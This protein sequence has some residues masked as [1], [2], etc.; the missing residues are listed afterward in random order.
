MK[1]RVRLMVM[2]LLPMLGMGVL[3]FLGAS[4]QLKQAIEEQ[5]YSGL[6]ATALAVREIFDASGQG[7]YRLDG[8]G[9]MW[10]G[11]E[12]NISD[13]TG[14]IDA[15]KEKI[16]YDITVFYGDTRIIT[17]IVDENGSRQ[18]GTKALDEVSAQVLGKGQDYR[19]GD[20]EILGN[21][22]LCY[23]IPIY[24]EGTKNPVGMVFLGERYDR[25]LEVIQESQA[26]VLLL[27][28]LVLMLVVVTSLISANRIAK[29]I[30]G[31]I[32]SLKELGKGKLGSKVSQKLLARKDEIGDMGREVQQLDDNLTAIISEIQLQAHTLEETSS[33]CNSN[34]QKALDSAEQVDAA[35][36]EVAASTTTQAQE[37]QEA[38]RSVNA[39]GVTI[40]KTNARMKE[41][42][43]TSEKMS[44]AAGSTRDTLK[45][46]NNSMYQVKDAV[47]NIQRQTNETHISVEKISE[48]TQVIT[49]IASQTNMLSLNASIEAAR[50]GEMG[51]GFA[52]VAEEIRKL[53][54]QC[55]TSV[56]EIQ[57]AL[58]QLK[59]NSD[60]SVSIM[61]DVQKNIQQQA[62]KLIAT[63]QV[64][65]TVENGIE[66]SMQGIGTIMDE[67]G[68]LNNE[69]NT[70]VEE[71]QSV[72]VLA[73]QNA[74]SIEETTA[75]ISEVAE[76]L[77]EMSAKMQDLQSVA[78]KL[79]EKSSTF[80]LAQAQ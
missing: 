13:A 50:A 15:I 41:I 49:S 2:V 17:T 51:K 40:D 76:I 21:R 3:S 36:E 67:I 58:V 19:N 24:Q 53:A 9:Q 69:R 23:Y 22:Y 14:M 26:V 77:A 20:V 18:V 57:E 56:V 32:D 30:K 66:Q 55:N 59:N 74:A 6:Q 72:A 71:V 39:I 54:E 43:Q 52:V 5:L 35:T 60:E 31:A 61:D 37:A 38:E 80:K 16:G 42:Y 63:N 48:M 8:E 75:S 34:V 4:V 11:E 65:R 29:A 78:D 70:A 46:L 68:L 47:D 33:I 45:E 28:L 1:L 7:E 44:E 10:K 25:V 12:M 27:M 64:F 79:E 73:Q 62:D